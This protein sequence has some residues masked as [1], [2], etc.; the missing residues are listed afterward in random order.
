MLQAPSAEPRATS[1]SPTAQVSLEPLQDSQV[2]TGNLW[3]FQQ[4]VLQ[5]RHKQLCQ[6]SSL[7]QAG[8]PRGPPRPQVRSRF[9]GESRSQ[10][11]PH[12]VLGSPK[13]RWNAGGRLVCREAQRS[14][15][16]FSFG[17]FCTRHRH[18]NT[19]PIL[20]TVEVI[21]YVCLENVMASKCKQKTVLLSI[22]PLDFK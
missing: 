19:M 8:N 15:S 1:E 20:I 13:A 18:E 16:G 14:H 9:L 17:L 12:R 22:S 4:T 6:V 21:A 10:Q 5:A 3:Q 11:A 2:P 7:E